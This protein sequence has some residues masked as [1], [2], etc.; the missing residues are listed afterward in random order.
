MVYEVIKLGVSLLILLLW[1]IK[2]GKSLLL[3]LIIRLVSIWLLRKARLLY[4]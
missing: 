2:Q 1:Q 3:S 4:L